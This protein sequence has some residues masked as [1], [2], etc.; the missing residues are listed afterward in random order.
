MRTI[1]IIL[2]AILLVSCKSQ[3][4]FS[5]M[6]QE[7]LITTEW[8]DGN[9]WAYQSKGDFIVGMTIQDDGEN[10]QIGLLIQNNSVAKVI[11]DPLDVSA[12]FGY[13]NSIKELQ[14]YTYEE[15]HK[16][17]K[18]NQNWE[19]A[20]AGLSAGL[21]AAN[22]GWSTTYVN[23]HPQTTYNYGAAA[24]VNSANM[25]NLSNMER[26]MRLERNAI[27]Y[28]YLKKNTIH[29]GEGIIGYMNIKRKGREGLLS[30]DI[31]VDGNN[32]PFLWHM[33]KK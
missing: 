30:I 13:G 14:V 2:A 26:I 31:T 25:M 17:V 6:E 12:K 18:K 11:F 33:Q 8:I 1:Y 20:L 3:K 22:A 4:V 9:L 10:Y 23:G 15:Y 16:K 7:P 32:F 21:N 5:L 27:K 24:A 29:P 19:L 28:G